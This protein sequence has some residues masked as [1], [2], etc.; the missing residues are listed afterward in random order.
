MAEEKATNPFLRAGEASVAAALGLS[1]QS[2]ETVF[3]E[4]RTRKDNA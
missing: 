4:I 2:A 3:T 1:G